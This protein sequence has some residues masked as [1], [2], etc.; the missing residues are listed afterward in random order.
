MKINTR[1]FKMSWLDDFF[2]GTPADQA[3]I[4][5]DS[6]MTVT[7]FNPLAYFEKLKA[8]GVPEN[9]AHVQ[10]DTLNEIFEVGLVTKKDLIILEGRLLYKLKELENKLTIRLGGM[11]IS[12][13]ALLGY[14]IKFGH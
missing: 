3:N 10:A 13:V 1:G 7:T 2:A 6:Y 11:F 5:E 9:Q 12:G 8:A 4:K 14:L